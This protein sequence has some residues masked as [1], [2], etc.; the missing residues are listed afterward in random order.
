MSAED[1]KPDTRNRHRATWDVG[2]DARLVERGLVH[3]TV[4]RGTVRAGQKCRSICSADCLNVRLALHPL[5][6]S[7]WVTVDKVSALCRYD[8]REHYADELLYTV[9]VSCA[10]VRAQKEF[11]VPGLRGLAGQAALHPL[12]VRS[13]SFGLGITPL[14]F[15][16]HSVVPACWRTFRCS[17]VKR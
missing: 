12:R 17:L 2:G 1:R 5:R 8:V 16:R 6:L 14:S 4:G 13:L 9:W 15:P 3:Y 11:Q 7:L 10:A